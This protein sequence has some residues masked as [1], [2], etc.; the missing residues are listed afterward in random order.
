MFDRKGEGL[1][2]VGEI[3]HSGSLG[4]SRHRGT[5][6]SLK[7]LGPGGQISASQEEN[8]SALLET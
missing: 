8:N 1:Q 4:Q 5:D 7:S 3:R 6:L 2:A